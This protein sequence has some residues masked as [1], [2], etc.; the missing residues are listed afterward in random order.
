MYIL[1]DEKNIHG[2]FSN[3]SY[4]TLASRFV[5]AEHGPGPYPELRIV[6]VHPDT[7]R[8]VDIRTLLRFYESAEK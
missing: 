1:K 2:V 7:I 3:E 6:H 4:A 5:Q 8:K